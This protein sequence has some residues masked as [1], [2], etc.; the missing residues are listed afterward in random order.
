MFC[1]PVRLQAVP[2]SWMELQAGLHNQLGHWLCCTLGQGCWP[3]S[4]VRWGHQLYPVVQWGKK[5]LFSWVGVTGRASCLNVPAVYV[6]QLG[7]TVGKALLWTRAVGWA[8]RLSRV[9]A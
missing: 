2:Q 3:C 4:L 9:M 7:K 8:P 1:D 5:L 6:Q